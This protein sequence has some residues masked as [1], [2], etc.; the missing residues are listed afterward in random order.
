MGEVNLL[1]HVIGYEHLSSMMRKEGE[2]AGTGAAWL[3]PEALW[4]CQLSR[5][6]FLSPNLKELS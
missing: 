3:M 4:N 2:H 6:K 5:P 1:H